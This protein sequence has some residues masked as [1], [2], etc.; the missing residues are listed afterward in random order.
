MITRGW[1][2]PQNADSLRTSTALE[3]G[4]WYDLDVRLE[5][6]QAEVRRGSRLGLVVLS[7]ERASTIRPAA[8]M[9]VRLDGSA[10]RLVL[11]LVR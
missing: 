7:T 2:D 6:M 8:G 10:S 1:T 11:P 4:A 9:R 5:G 3:P